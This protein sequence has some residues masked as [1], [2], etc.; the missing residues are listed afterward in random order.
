MGPTTTD[1]KNIANQAT[2]HI[3]QLVRLLAAIAFAVIR[4]LVALMRSTART[5]GRIA[6]VVLKIALVSIGIALVAGCA[7]DSAADTPLEAEPSPV[8][9]VATTPT[10]VPPPTATAVAVALPTATPEPTPSPTPD[11]RLA[12]AEEV[13]TEYYLATWDILG[14]ARNVDL[15]RALALEHPSGSLAGTA[16]TLVTRMLDTNTGLE[17]DGSRLEVRSDQTRWTSFD[18][19]VDS[20][21]LAE[22]IAVEFCVQ[23]TGHWRDLDTGELAFES[24]PDPFVATVWI[25]P[26]DLLVWG[27]AEHV[28]FRPC[29]FE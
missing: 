7:G 12:Q 8:A 25:E 19:E 13:A 26:T 3:W 4:L 5:L 6:G 1:L 16:I 2:S 27:M 14:D 23:S 29:E 24:H 11:P 18:D 20:L 22:V 28:P 17:I 21:D 15:T 9:A 10:A